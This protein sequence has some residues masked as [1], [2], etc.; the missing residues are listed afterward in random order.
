MDA[1]SIAASYVRAAN[2]SAIA[3]SLAQTVS[4]ASSVTDILAANAAPKIQAVDYY[5][6]LS[7]LRA[8]QQA[9]PDV[10][11]QVIQQYVTAILN[12]VVG[13]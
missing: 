2:V 13:A 12:Q 1:A 11:T 6:L 8:I 4:P 10:T 7:A 3:Q 5:T 9:S